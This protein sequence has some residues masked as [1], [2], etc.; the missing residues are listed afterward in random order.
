MTKNAEKA[1]NEVRTGWFRYVR[2][3]DVKK[4]LQMGWMVVDDLEPTHG[5]WSMLMWR[6]DCRQTPMENPDANRDQH[7]S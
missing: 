2:H 4:F 3:N 7:N 5:M 6:C 1:R